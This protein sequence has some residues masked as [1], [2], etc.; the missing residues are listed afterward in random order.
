MFEKHL[1]VV[2][3]LLDIGFFL[4]REVSSEAILDDVA[5]EEAFK[6]LPHHLRSEDVN[7]FYPTLAVVVTTLPSGVELVR[8]FTHANTP[9]L[10]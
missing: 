10:L 2:L 3:T 8:L 9:L 1:A 7:Y 5:K 6:L 4:P